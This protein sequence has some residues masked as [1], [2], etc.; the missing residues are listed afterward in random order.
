[1]GPLY[2]FANYP[3]AE[4]AADTEN[5]TKI[6]VAIG[7]VKAGISSR[8]RLRNVLMLTL[9]GEAGLPVKSHFDWFIGPGEGPGEV[10][11]FGDPCSEDILEQRAKDAEVHARAW[12]S[13]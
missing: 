6:K 7:A 4:A 9:A 1:M 8:E 5:K 12:D 2:K 3:F 10:V 11:L 13:V